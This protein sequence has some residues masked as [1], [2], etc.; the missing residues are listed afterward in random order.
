MVVRHDVLHTSSRGRRQL[1]RVADWRLK[2]L[3]H[4]V[5]TYAYQVVCASGFLMYVYTPTYVCMDVQIVL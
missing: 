3:I 2:R 5:C 4:D 1:V